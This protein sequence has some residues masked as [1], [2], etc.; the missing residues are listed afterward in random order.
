VESSKPKE[1]AAK[2]NKLNSKINKFE[3][4]ATASKNWKIR[5]SQIIVFPGTPISDA[6]T[7]I[8]PLVES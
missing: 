1:R 3:V 8:S 7:P 5:L 4:R 2:A 6:K